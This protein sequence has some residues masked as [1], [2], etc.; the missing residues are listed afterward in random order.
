MSHILRKLPNVLY[1][2]LPVFLRM[3]LYGAFF[4]VSYKRI[5]QINNNIVSKIFVNI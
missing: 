5:H 3:T 1:H 4:P 2:R